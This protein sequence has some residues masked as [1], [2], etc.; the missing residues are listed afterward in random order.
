MSQPNTGPARERT[1]A[2]RITPSGI[3]FV[4]VTLLL[5]VLVASLPGGVSLAG[6]APSKTSTPD[7]TCGQVVPSPNRG[8][9]NGSLYSV[10]AVS[11]ND[12]WA[13]GYNAN[14][15]GVGTVIEHWNGTAWSIVPG[16]VADYNYLS[17]VAA[18]SAN[19]VWAVGYIR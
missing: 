5:A 11:A 3:L 12:V 8:T 16:P 17:G 4:G 13:V 19:D 2:T 1:G 9:S 7:D 14:A 10:A 6:S 15:V 18:V